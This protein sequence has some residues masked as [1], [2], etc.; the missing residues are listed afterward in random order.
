[1]T[2][3]LQCRQ[4]EE[5]EEQLSAKIA[6]QHIYPNGFLIYIEYLEKS[7]SSGSFG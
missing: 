3:A 4:K 7:D 5:Q 6:P 2:D 1:M